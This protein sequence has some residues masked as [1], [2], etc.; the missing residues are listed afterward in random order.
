MS[1]LTEMPGRCLWQ[2]NGWDKHKSEDHGA[3]LQGGRFG[4]NVGGVFYGIKLPTPVAN[5]NMHALH[6][7]R[8]AKCFQHWLSSGSP[9]T[10]P[11]SRARSS[12]GKWKKTRQGSGEMILERARSP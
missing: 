10:E 1:I 8:C 2:D 9:E 4:I 6:A 5:M 12:F 7:G 3:H 11:E